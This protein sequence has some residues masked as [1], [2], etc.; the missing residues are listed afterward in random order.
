MLEF[1]FRSVMD[2]VTSSVRV[3]IDS[4]HFGCRFGYGSWS[5]GSSFR[6]QVGFAKSIWNAT[7]QAS[8]VQVEC[9]ETS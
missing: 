3:Q 8:E 9:V 4:F 7:S 5:F 6:S 1:R 2:R